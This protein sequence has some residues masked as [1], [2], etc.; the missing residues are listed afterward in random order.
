MVRRAS[1]REVILDKYP[2]G[3]LYS[4]PRLYLGHVVEL[5]HTVCGQSLMGGRPPKPLEPCKKKEE[6]EEGKVDFRVKRGVCQAATVP[7]SRVY[8]M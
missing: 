3:G 7:K 1:W 5:Q 6:E 8:G 4:V 2:S